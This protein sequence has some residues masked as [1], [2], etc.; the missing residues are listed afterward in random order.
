[1][2]GVE[3]EMKKGGGESGNEDCCTRDW[4][5]GGFGLEE[6]EGKSGEKAERES[7]R[8]RVE[9]GAIEREVGGRAEVGAEEVAVGDDSRED[10]RD[11][12]RSGEPREGGALK[13]IR[14]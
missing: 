13:S 2:A 8:E 4:V 10:D 11:C 6:E 3:G 5:F 9:V 7:G 12:R 14:S 1:L